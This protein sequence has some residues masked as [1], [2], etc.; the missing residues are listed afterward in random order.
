MDKLKFKNLKISPEILKSLELLGY[1]VLSKVQQ[2]SIPLAMEGKD[3]IVKSQTGSGKTAAF[4][5]PIC[6]KIDI[7]ERKPQALVLTPT[8]ELAVQIK[9]DIS[10]I[11]RFKK[12]R[13]A[14]IFGK[15]PMT[16]QMRELKQRVHVV[17]G[18]P[19]R[20]I[21]HIERKNVDF[22]EIKY[23]V[24]DEADEMMNMGFID[25]VEEI[26]N[27]LPSKRVTML[28]SATMPEKIKLLCDKYMI[29]PE[30]IEVN[31]DNITVKNIYQYYYEVEEKNKNSLLNKVIYSE[32]PDSCIIFCDTKDQ[33]DKLYQA[34]KDEKYS[35]LKLHGGMEQKDRLDVIKS[36]KKGESRFLVTTDVLSRGIHIEDV[37]HVINFDLPVEKENYVHRIGRTGRAGKEGTAITFVTPNED[38]FLN[39]IEEYIESKIPRKEIPSNEDIEKG[40]KIFKAKIKD[41]LKLKKDKSTEI[42][43]NVMKI[44]IHGGRKKK[45]RPGDIVGAITSIEDVNME[46]IGII[47]IQDNCSYVDILDNKGDK[48]L[49]A[50]QNTK[51]KGKVLRVQKSIK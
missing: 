5:I 47:D 2:S 29:N 17:V 1:K 33:V 46:D 10:N 37:T 32:A 50:L 18:T 19:G 49:K 15:Q 6:E 26:I 51:I 40:K 4:A 11:G 16:T 28:F 38:M 35:C 36:F 20:T 8:R 27:T 7:E 21:D 23:L 30:S 45:I 39:E 43:K 14:A 13:C 3:I 25:Q 31:P 22:S 12:I 42:N 48:V 9:D 24:I 44:H 41:G 34:M